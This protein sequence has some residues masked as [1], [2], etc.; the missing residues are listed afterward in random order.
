MAA[1][2]EPQASGRPGRPCGG[3]ATDAD[4]RFG[5]HAARP[6]RLPEENRPCTTLLSPAAASAAL[7]ATSRLSPSAAGDGP[8]CPRGMTPPTACRT[9]IA[10]PPGTSP[11]AA[12]AGPG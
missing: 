8:R 7:T 6:D 4:A 10:G 2:G 9:A 5:I 3:R 1:F 11:P 12:S